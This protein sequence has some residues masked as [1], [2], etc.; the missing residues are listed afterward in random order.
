M[1]VKNWA[2]VVTAL[3][4][5]WPAGMAG[6]TTV[7]VISFQEALLDTADMQKESAALEARYKPRQDEIERISV[8]LQEI[9]EKLPGLQGPELARMQSEG[10]RKQRTAQ[11]LSEDLQSDVEFDRQNILAGATARMRDIIRDLRLEKGIDLIVDG[12]GVLAHSA[13]ID[14][15]AEATQAYDAKHP[16]N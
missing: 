15:T 13:L 9:Q 5:A 8:E 16:A 4:F 14:L 12:G 7:A 10:Q 1:K 6:Q 3:L 2:P 11:R